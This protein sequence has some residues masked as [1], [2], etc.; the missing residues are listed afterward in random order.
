MQ[1]RIEFTLENKTEWRRLSAAALNESVI[2]AFGGA[3][4]GIEGALLSKD[5]HGD[6]NLYGNVDIFILVSGLGPETYIESQYG[7]RLL[8]ALSTH[9]KFTWS[10]DAFPPFK[11]SRGSPARSKLSQSKIILH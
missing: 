8:T 9:E 10:G 3:M 6:V 1:A 2:G 4:R 11:S 5:R 7:K